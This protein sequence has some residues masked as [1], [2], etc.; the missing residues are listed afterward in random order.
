MSKESCTPRKPRKHRASLLRLTADQEREIISYYRQ[1]SSIRQ[2][3]LEVGISRATLQRWVLGPL[4]D[5]LEKI[6]RQDRKRRAAP[7]QR[8]HPAPAA[9]IVQDDRGIIEQDIHEDDQVDQ[10]RHASRGNEAPETIVEYHP[11]WQFGNVLTS[12]GEREPGVPGVEIE[13]G[14]N[15]ALCSRCRQYIG[16]DQ[17]DYLFDVD[18]AGVH[19]PVC[20]DCRRDGEALHGWPSAGARQMVAVPPRYSGEKPLPPVK[21]FPDVPLV[22]TP[23]S[24]WSHLQPPVKRGASKYKRDR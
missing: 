21:P 10:G 18:A 17:H 12:R 9:E 2:I 7:E 14:P 4:S 6:V 19:R 11:E 3:A 24:P 1:G 16:G 5:K 23:P 22:K 15:G 8:N 20:A 13:S